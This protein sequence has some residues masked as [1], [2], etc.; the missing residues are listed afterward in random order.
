MAI[1]QP[2]KRYT[3]AGLQ[4]PNVNIDTPLTQDLVAAYWFNELVD[5]PIN[6]VDNQSAVSVTNGLW[7][8]GLHGDAYRSDAT[9]VTVS[10]TADADTFIPTKNV[11]IILGYRKTDATSRAAYAFAVDTATGGEKC[12]A[13]LPYSDGT[14]YWHFGGNGG[15]N[16]VSASSLTFGNDIWAV[17]AGDHGME[18]WQNGVSVASSGTAVTRSATTGDFALGL[19]AGVG[20][21]LADFHHL[22]IWQRVLSDD[23]IRDVTADINILAQPEYSHALLAGGAGGG[24]DFMWRRRWA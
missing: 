23:E 10:L 17:T 6:S 18:M 1:G 16:A 20:S 8:R 2:I 4:T 12:E 21:D 24:T 14:A 22:H 3:G 5:V 19:A 15:S 7:T 11:T 13:H 9:D